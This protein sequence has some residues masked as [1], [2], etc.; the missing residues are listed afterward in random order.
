MKQPAKSNNPKNI[1]ATYNDA[2]R[3]LKEFADSN[4]LP[5]TFCPQITID[6]Q[7]RE[8]FADL[9]INNKRHVA[10]ILQIKDYTDKTF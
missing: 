4:E 2:A 10:R 8:V 6:C 9:L 1:E 5:D 7:K 3:L